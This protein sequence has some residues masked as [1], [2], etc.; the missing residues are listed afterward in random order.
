M[1]DRKRKLGISMPILNNPYT[2]FPEMAAEAD[3]AGFDSVWDYEF[4]R[5]PFIIHALTA[6]TTR[7]IVLA[8]GIAAAAG[9]TPFEMAN[10]VA[11]VDELSNGRV[12]LGMSTGGEGFAECFNG[13]EIDRPVSRL[14]EYINIM[15]MAWD[16]LDGGTPLEYEGRFYRCS[17]PPVNPWGQRKL[18]RPRIPIYLG[19]LRPNMLRLAGKMADGVLGFFLSPRFVEEQWAPYVAEGAADAGRDPADIDLTALVLCSVSEDR[20]QAMRLARINVGMYVAAPV[21]TFIADFMGLGEERDAVVKA[22]MSEG[23]KALATV[24]SDALVKAFAIT[25]TPDECR[26]QLVEYQRV[27]DHVVLHTPYVP[28]IAGA[29]ST[30]AF[31][32]T[33]SFL[34]PGGS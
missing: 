1:T 34:A 14:G 26:E 15:R 2:V 5:N 8:T 9:R 7:N 20:E 22:L 12:L 16:H 32:N 27:L 3:A 29:E 28:P 4:Y 25:G 21:S 13:T 6:R 33:V 24:T 18:V 17:A 10:A 11:D 19:A 31:H 23:P 30:E